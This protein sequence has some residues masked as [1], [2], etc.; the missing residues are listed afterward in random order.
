MDRR[1]LLL[2]IFI[3][4]QS[5]RILWLPREKHD[6]KFPLP[7]RHQRHWRVQ[8]L[9]YLCDIHVYNPIGLTLC[10][11]TVWLKRLRKNMNFWEMYKDF[12]QRAQS[13]WSLA[14]FLLETRSVNTWQTK[15]YCY[16]AAPTEIPSLSLN[17]LIMYKQTE[18]LQGAWCPF[19]RSLIPQSALP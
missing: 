12:L 2:L 17:S 15:A 11:E 16:V 7:Y 5:F 3:L 13:S 1:K 19:L 6:T 8:S 4:L 10:K 9:K 14:L 18:H